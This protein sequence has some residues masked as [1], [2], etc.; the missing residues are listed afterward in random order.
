MLSL[1]GTLSPVVELNGQLGV[2]VLEGE[3]YTPVY[4][5]PYNVI[6]DFSVQRLPTANKKCAADV[7]VQK[8][9][10][11]TTSNASGGNTVWIGG[12]I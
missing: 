7:T 6:P 11:E 8:I 5:G 12:I 1:F 10:V 3:S 2:G 9:P 4:N